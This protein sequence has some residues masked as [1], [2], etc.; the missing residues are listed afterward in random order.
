[1]NSLFKSG[2]YGGLVLLLGFVGVVIWKI[3]SGEISLRGLLASKPDT[4]HPS[5]ERIQLFV[6]TLFVAGRYVLAVIG[7]PHRDSLPDL[8]AAFVAVLGASQAIYLAVKAWPRFRPL[9]QKM[10]SGDM[11]G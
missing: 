1:M 5:I 2:E 10:K 3:A 9:L 6:V 7:N 4:H 8:P 11:H